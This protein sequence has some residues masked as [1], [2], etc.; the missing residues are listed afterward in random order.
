MSNGE[1]F[2]L[3][4]TLLPFVELRSARHSNGC[5]S[6]HSH[7][8]FSL[9]VIDQGAADYVNLKRKH[10]IG[11]G[12]SVTINPGDVHSCNPRDGDWSYRML[13][14]DTHWLGELQR[15]SGLGSQDY[16][17]FSQHY[18]EGRD[19]YVRIDRLYHS[20]LRGDSALQA[21]ELLLECCLGLF[22]AGA[23][24][25]G[26]YS[27]GLLQVQQKIMD[28]LDEN[29]SLQELSELA[30][31]SRCHLVRSFKAHFGL[32]PHAYQL[33]QRILRARTLLQRGE[34]LADTAAQLGF[35]D[36]SHFQR[37]FKKRTALTPRRYQQLI[38]A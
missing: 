36:Q 10:H 13:F 37:N 14:I 19:N 25:G 3:K 7:D 38:C 6:L 27:Q 17:A 11:R 26:G 1:D 21:E 34:S 9:G 24:Q 5:Y 8:E 15:E 31:L 22:G 2:L 29:L 30:Q 4:S 23:Q 28:Q 18:L 33:D 32:S 12:V 16:R 35:A 20:L